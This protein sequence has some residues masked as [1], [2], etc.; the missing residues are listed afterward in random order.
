MLALLLTLT[1]TPGP[2]LFAE[3]PEIVWGPIAALFLAN[4]MLLVMNV[5]LVKVLALATGAEIV[6]CG[7]PPNL[8]SSPPCPCC[9]AT[10]QAVPGTAPGSTNAARCVRPIR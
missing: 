9:A 8:S 6:I 3:R 4:I 7:R 2:R 5:P 10:M 1:I